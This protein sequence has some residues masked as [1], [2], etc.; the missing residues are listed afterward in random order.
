MYIFDL[1]SGCLDL[2]GLLLLI[3]AA[4]ILFRSCS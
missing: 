1:F 2:A 3:I 4:I